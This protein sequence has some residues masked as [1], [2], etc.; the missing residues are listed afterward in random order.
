MV[1]VKMIIEKLET[2]EDRL[3]RIQAKS[4]LALK[5]QVIQLEEMKK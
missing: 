4:I 2:E 5:L 1:L 3:I